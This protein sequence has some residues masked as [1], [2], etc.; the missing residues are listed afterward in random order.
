MS[1]ILTITD[2]GRQA[3]VD[4]QNT[5][6]NKVTISHIAI[7]SGLYDPNAQQTALVT[8]I[9]TLDTFGGAVVADDV[10]HVTIRDESEDV[11]SLGEFGLLT[12]T[13]VLF[14]V[15]S[16]TDEYILEKNASGVMVLSVDATITTID[17]QQLE[18]GGTGFMLPPGTETVAGVLALADNVEALAGTDDSRAMTSKKTKAVL[19]AHRAEANA[20]DWTNIGGK[21]TTFP[22]SA[23]GHPWSAITE[24]PATFPP[25]AHQHALSEITDAGSAA[26]KNM[27]TETEAKAGKAGVVPDA[28]GMLATI[29]QWGYGGDS[30]AT[31]NLDTISVSGLYDFGAAT[32]S[33][34]PGDAG[35]LLH[36][37]VAGSVAGAQFAS[38]RSGTNKGKFFWRTKTSSAWGA[39]ST[40]LAVGDYG[41]GSLASP[42]AI[43]LS[44]ITENGFYRA[45]TTTTGTPISGAAFEVVHVNYD[46]NSAKQ[47]AWQAGTSTLRH[48]ERVKSGG[49]WSAWNESWHN[50]NLTMAE[51][52]IDATQGRVSR[53]GDGG[54]LWTPY[55]D[56]SDDLIVDL[57]AVKHTGF[58][59]A[60]GTNIANIPPGVSGSEVLAVETVCRGSDQAYI[61]QKATTTRYNSTRGR[62]YERTYSATE[63][64]WSDWV[65]VYTSGNSHSHAYIDGGDT[66]DLN[67]VA[68]DNRGYFTFS[69]YNSSAAN[70]PAATN[71]ANGVLTMTTH[72]GPYGHQIA[73]GSYNDM[74]HRRFDNGT[75]GGWLKIIDSDNVD[76]AI[77]GHISAQ[78]AGGV[79]TYALLKN[80][81]TSS[82]QPGQTTAG[83][84]LCYT[85]ADGYITSTAAISGT[86]RCM[87]Y[88][89]GTGEP[90]E[91]KRTTVWMRI[92]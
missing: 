51:S 28:A 46:A 36:I 73:F 31:S 19:D 62:S 60:Y 33:P 45:S 22:P 74:Y 27:A 91:A 69:P 63:A 61:W 42:H 85:D 87:G 78:P 32:G 17:V 7:G 81:T 68:A 79:G 40:G 43:D 64:S 54:L 65:E 25:S 76:T 53:V 37:A 15:Y 84:N 92:S 1:L 2:A 14:A 44:A 88:V 16:Q 75:Y 3:L 21:P 71:N 57:N 20:H 82:F 86:W 26:A 41:L 30:V 66:G 24:K 8:P 38:I 6:V 83:S 47:V 89:L 34:S 48:F 50:G 35:Q 58:F 67:A 52:V 59:F 5:G 72:G 49:V 77:D 29:Q 13:G 39:W 11:Y 55:Y 12:D 9:K 56:S 10:I 80:K 70:K 4:A 90:V 18:F 23:H